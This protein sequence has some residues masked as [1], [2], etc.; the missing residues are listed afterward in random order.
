[1]FGEETGIYPMD[2]KKV[3]NNGT[4]TK[5]MSSRSEILSK[6][7]A[8]KPEYKE[9]EKI[10]LNFFKEDIDLL[11]EFKRKVEIVGGKI[12]SAKSNAEILSQ[13]KVLYPDT[14][15]NY[16]YLKGSED[17]N[18]FEIKKIKK[19]HEL[20][21]LD[22]LI[23]EGVFGVAENG[24]IWITDEDF[25]VR[26]LPFITK[27]LVV[28]IDKK[29]IVPYMHQAYTRLKDQDYNFGLFLSG[30]SKTADIEQALVIGAQGALTLNVFLLN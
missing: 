26:V 20:E 4:K 7:K 18:S 25:P 8:S 30:P 5:K 21:D 13:V 11:E 1:M 3:L 2:Q 10:D 6:I 17:F 22:L 28:V 27:H 24:A 23:L 14:K 9:L 15:K 19:P 12:F 16:S 29:E